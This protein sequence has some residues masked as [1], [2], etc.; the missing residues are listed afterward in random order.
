MVCSREKSQFLCRKKDVWDRLAKETQRS[1]GLVAQL[2]TARQEVAE[3][4]PIARELAD[5]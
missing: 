1:E 5:L 4:A 3:L 2:A